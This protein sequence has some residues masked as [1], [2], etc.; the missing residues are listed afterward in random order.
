MKTRL[1]FLVLLIV[2]ISCGTSN[3][4]VSDAQKE[5]IKGEIKEIQNT[6]IKALEEI[7]WD[8]AI[9]PV[10]D[11]PD[12]VYTYHGKTSNYEEFMASELD[13]NTRLNQKCT[14]VDEKYAVLDNSTVLYT[15]N[16]TWLTNFKNGH[17]VLADPAVTQVLYKKI[18]NR[19][20]VI[21]IFESGVE[22][23]VNNTENETTVAN[24]LSQIWKEYLE[25]IKNKDIDKVMSY[26]NTE[27]YI[28]YPFYGSAQ[29]GFEESKSFLKDFIENN[30][31]GEL[32]IEQIEVKVLGDF[33][34]E[35]ALMEQKRTSEGESPIITKQ[36]SFSI[37]KK[38]SDGSWK[39]Y[40]W[41]GQQ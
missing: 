40:R 12:F 2:C 34:F 35:T 15:M 30:T 24:Q 17:S 6:T 9:E 14:I 39:F 21:N 26:H 28:N 22:Q 18:D 41:I 13:F 3:K 25:A 31:M 33:A 4:P 38:Q 19:W 11:S 37:F 7:D 20:R 10:F 27:D 1:I 8:M 36:R 32:N 5:K 23:S 29:K 16:C